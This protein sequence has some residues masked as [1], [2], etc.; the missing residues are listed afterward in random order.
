MKVETSVVSHFTASVDRYTDP[1]PAPGDFL[2]RAFEQ[3][4]GQPLRVLELGCGTGHR[5]EGLNR[6]HAD[7]QLF[8]LDITPI[9]VQTARQVRPAPISFMI[10]DCLT[11]PFADGLFNGIIIYN[12]LHHL[13]TDTKE[14]SNRLRENGLSELVRLLAPGGR[15]VLE[16]HCV[17]ATWRASLIFFF[18][19]LVSR[20]HLSIPALHIH[21]DVV[22]NFFALEE[23]DT[24]FTRSGLRVVQKEVDR[25]PGL[26]VRIATFG[27]T[28]YQFRCVLERVA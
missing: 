21:T 3:N 23:L 8:G 26:A 4:A 12:V 13:I 15:I 18:S 17:N 25:F 22:T 9:M 5:L 6:D 24:A 11:V 27:D 14:K 20:L 1:P 7:F 16:E 19:H 10:G 28:T 2:L